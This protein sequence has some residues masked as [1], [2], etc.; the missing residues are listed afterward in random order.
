MKTKSKLTSDP[1][2]QQNVGLE[3]LNLELLYPHFFPAII[4][5]KAK[6]NK[7]DISIH[8]PIDKN[9]RKPFKI[10]KNDTNLQGNLR[11]QWKIEFQLKQTNHKIFP[12]Q[13]KFHVQGE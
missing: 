3:A 11:T 4:T 5:M 13:N 7:Y 1:F 9:S 10:N 12:K 8:H 6:N 2:L